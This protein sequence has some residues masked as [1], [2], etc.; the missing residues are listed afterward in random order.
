[1][2]PAPLLPLTE[3]RPVDAL[4]ADAAESAMN[5]AKK[6]RVKTLKFFD[7]TADVS[8]SGSDRAAG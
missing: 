5:P 7:G 4:A 1:M 2:P 3:T 8:T 6:K